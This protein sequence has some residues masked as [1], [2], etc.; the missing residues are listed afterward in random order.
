MSLTSLCG[1]KALASSLNPKNYTIG[2][3]LVWLVAFE[4]TS[5]DD[6]LV[7]PHSKVENT[8]ISGIGGALGITLSTDA[9]ALELKASFTKFGNLRMEATFLESPPSVL[10][11]P[12]PM[13]EVGFGASS[14][15]AKPC[16]DSEPTTL[17]SIGS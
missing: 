9:V 5:C 17:Y 2:V 4:C 8:L 7:L 6:G 1:A 11:I 16:Q 13:E 3:G 12:I 10:K 14:R 15:I